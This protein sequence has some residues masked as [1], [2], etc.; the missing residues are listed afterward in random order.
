MPYRQMNLGVKK[1]PRRLVPTGTLFRPPRDPTARSL[2]IRVGT[3][4]GP[5]VEDVGA[6]GTPHGS[7]VMTYGLPPTKRQRH[8]ALLSQLLQLADEQ[9]R[10]AAIAANN[11]RA[12]QRVP[13]QAAGQRLYAL[14]IAGHSSPARRVPGSAVPTRPRNA[15]CPQDS[16]SEALSAQHTSATRLAGSWRQARPEDGGTVRKRV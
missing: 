11:G 5:S 4:A 7:E 3:V 16:S 2:V 15:P 8:V 12:R 14:T 1:S 6:Q 10:R 13:R 9:L